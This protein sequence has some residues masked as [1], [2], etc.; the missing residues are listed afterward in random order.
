LDRAGANP[1]AL[2]T[3]E[4]VTGTR[5]VVGP[6]NIGSPDPRFASMWASASGN[7]FGG[8]RQ[9]GFV[10]QFDTQTGNATL[11]GRTFTDADGITPLAVDGWCCSLDCDPPIPG[12][13]V[14]TLS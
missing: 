1:G 2:I 13:G 5:S 8:N 10:Y 6:T 12:I 7:V 3:I 11:I 9:N 4:I 14:P